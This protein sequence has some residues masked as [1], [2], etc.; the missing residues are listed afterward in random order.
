METINN[1]VHIFYFCIGSVIFYNFLIVWVHKKIDKRIRIAL[2]VFLIVLGFLF[3][4]AGGKV[5]SQ[6]ADD[7]T[8]TTLVFAILSPI[9]ISYL[10]YEVL[11]YFKSIDR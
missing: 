4:N 10:V 5:M 2:S 6:Y 8:T 3:F 9:S 7:W 1:Y 11:R